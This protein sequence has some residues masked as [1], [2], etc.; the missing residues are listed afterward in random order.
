MA[1]LDRDGGDPGGRAC[2]GDGPRLR[3]TRGDDRRPGEHGCTS[4]R[5]A[6]AGPRASPRRDHRAARRVLRARRST[7]TCRLATFN[8][9][10]AERRDHR[11]RRGR[12]DARRADPQHRP[13]GRLDRRPRRLF[14]RARCSRN[15][16]DLPPLLVVGAVRSSS[17]AVLG[18]DQRR[19]RRL[20]PGAR[21]HRRR[22]ARSRSIRVLLVELSGA[23]TVT[24]DCLPDWLVDLPRLNL[25]TIGTLDIRPLV[26]IALADR[27][28]LPARTALPAVRPAALRDRLQPGRGAQSPACRSSATSS[29]AFV[30]SR[31]AGR[32]RRL[33]VPARFGNITVDRRT[34]PRAAGRRRGGGRRRQ[35]LR[36]HRVDRSA[37]CSAPC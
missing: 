8:R 32:P 3:A 35:H 2:R 31:R 15:D 26:V 17:A 37:P 16:Q 33:H 36:R 20:G 27:R 14:R 5:P 24:T 6:R 11:R 19:H 7:T 29:C 12:P 30:L 18:C 10:S 1:I 22:S 34:G 25:L 9:I 4:P 28:R 13:V 23:K 21:D